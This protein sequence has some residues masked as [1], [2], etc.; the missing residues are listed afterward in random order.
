MVGV[1]VG[2]PGRA[3]ARAHGNRAGARAQSF[4]RWKKP[5][6]DDELALPGFKAQ[7]DEV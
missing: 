5:G 3:G 1:E 6:A 4:V 2:V 7:D